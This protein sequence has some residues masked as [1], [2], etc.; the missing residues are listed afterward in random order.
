MASW[1]QI[2]TKTPGTNSL[3]TE[4]TVGSASTFSGMLEQDNGGMG[5]DV[6]DI[7]TGMMV[8]SRI[9]ASG[10]YSTS[11]S[12]IMP[13]ANQV[14]GMNSSS[15]FGAYN[16]ED[17]HEHSNYVQHDENSTITGDLNI[18]GTL[19]LD[20]LEVNTLSLTNV[21]DN[22]IKINTDNDGNDGG[23]KVYYTGAN[24]GTLSY[25]NS[26]DRWVMGTSAAVAAGTA[27]TLGST[28]VSA[29]ENWAGAPSVYTG[30]LG[31]DSNNGNVYVAIP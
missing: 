17:T 8:A 19:A 14:I 15:V 16:V 7:A 5:E 6:S 3:P 20:A 23:I 4:I 26:E 1:K 9:G 21:A 25:D 13:A 31:L 18:D 22:Y 28:L 29:T 12:S 30:T 24:D 27:P 10:S 2:L 11:W